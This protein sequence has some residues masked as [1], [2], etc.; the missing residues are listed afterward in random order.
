VT[1]NLA[2]QARFPFLS[3]NIL[4][5][6]TRTPP[7]WLKSS[8]YFPDLKLELLC[9]T[10][11]E[12]REVAVLR[13]SAGLEFEREER[14][15]ERYGW[16]RPSSGR[17]RILLA[18]VSV[19]R[20][21]ELAAVAKVDAILG[22]HSHVR[23]IHRWGNVL[24]VQAG[25]KA[26]HI[27]R[28][29][30]AI[31]RASGRVV[32]ATSKIELLRPPPTPVPEV[33]AVLAKY[34]PEIDRVMNEVVGE[35]AVELSRNHP[36]R[37]SPLGSYL[38]D[39]MRGATGAEVAFHNRAGIRADLAVGPV[40]RRDLYQVS[41]FQ[42]TL[43]TMNLTGEQVLAVLR[44]SLSEPRLLLETSGLELEYE[45]G[46]ILWVRVNGQPLEPRREYRIVTNS[47]LAKRGDGQEAFG[48][49]RE[50]K[51]TYLD[52]LQLHIE[53]LRKRSPLSY[54]APERIRPRA[55]PVKS[56]SPA[57]PDPSASGTGASTS[58]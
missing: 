53:D 21:R 40:R 6:G 12:I 36:G 2:R 15:L 20:A 28:L 16:T 31:D 22:G 9:L 45:P 56:A 27:G 44:H 14:T 34:A 39:L 25:S 37:S 47:F 26:A 19:E 54:Q 4:E 18:H 38:C 1:E 42:N 24:Y 57:V 5:E 13:A 58:R 50:V 3:A 48:L 49:G 33:Q 8:L 46:R 51:D 11:S 29:D 23:A 41:P 10:I 7:K 32:S 35:L 43:V 17:T 52:L 55:A 30:L